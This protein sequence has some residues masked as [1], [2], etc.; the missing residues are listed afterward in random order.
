MPNVEL[1]KPPVLLPEGVQAAPALSYREPIRIGF[2]GHYR[3]GEKDVDGIIRAFLR[4]Q[5]ADKAELVVQAAPTSAEDAEDMQRIMEKYKYEKSVR[6]IKGKVLGK[7]WYDLLKSVDV[8]FLPYSNPRY[9]YNWSAVY[10]NALALYKPVL[11][12]SVLN[13]EV[14]ADY[15]VGAEVNLKDLEQLSEQLHGFLQNY[16]AQLPVYERELR[17]AN[18]DFS[19]GSFL[20]SLL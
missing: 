12:T 16:Q 4:C 7:G 14:L 5:M 10:F 19:T 9:L 17:R 20:Q 6:F 2:F 8:L 13:P 3:K 18:H 15:E 11:V 1:I